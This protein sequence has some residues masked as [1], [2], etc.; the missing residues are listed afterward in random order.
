MEWQEINVAE[1]VVLVKVAGLVI[2]WSWILMIGAHYV[3]EFR[4]GYWNSLEM[5]KS[6][7]WTHV[8]CLLVK[9]EIVRMWQQ[10]N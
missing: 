5:L 1:N 7:S 6:W 9:V 10:L 4:F 8:E 2:K 3:E